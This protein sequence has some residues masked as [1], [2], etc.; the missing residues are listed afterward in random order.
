M[1]SKSTPLFVLPLLAIMTPEVNAAD[2]VVPP[3]TEFIPATY[4]SAE[5]GLIWTDYGIAESGDDKFGDIQDD[6]GF[7]AAVTFRRNINPSWDW[8]VT[9]TATWL[10]G[11]SA[12]NAFFGDYFDTDMDFQ[13]VDVDLGYHPGDN[14]QTRILF[15]ARFLHATESLNYSEEF[16]EF[17]R[18]FNSE[19]WAVGPRIGFQSDMPLGNSNFGFVTEASGSILFGTF[20]TDV[21]GEDWGAEFWKQSSS[22]TRIVYNL[23]ALAGLSWHPTQ[24]LTFTAGYRA[25]QWWGIR[26]NTR[27]VVSDFDYSLRADD[28]ILVHGPFARVG[29]TF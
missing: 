3:P 5:G 24:S 26:N 4:I 22:N 11:I 18:T 23:E 25:Q 17:S 9:G 29:L 14:P 7:Y 20:D 27:I 28:D 21:S 6:D 10:N 16:N 1:H 8:Q 2:L 19:G 12:R 13:T 15:G